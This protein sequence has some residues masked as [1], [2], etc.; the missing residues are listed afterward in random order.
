[1]WIKLLLGGVKHVPSSDRKTSL[2]ITNITPKTLLN[3]FPVTLDDSNLIVRF[4]DDDEDFG[5]LFG[6]HDREGFV[7]KITGELFEDAEKLP[8]EQ[9]NPEYFPSLEVAEESRKD[10]YGTLFDHLHV[11]W[12]EFESDEAFTLLAFNGIGMYYLAGIPNDSKFK[13]KLPSAAVQID[14]DFMHQFACREPY[15]RYGCIAYFDI[16]KAPVAIYW[17]AGDK[18]V[19]PGDADWEHA[20]FVFRC[21]L[22][23]VI[24]CK[25]HLINLHWQVSNTLMFASRQSL[26]EHHALRRLI[27]PHT[28]RVAKINWVSRATL[29]PING[30]AHRTFAL[31]AGAFHEFMAVGIR[32]LKFQTF[33]DEIQSK[34]LP[35]EIASDLPYKVDGEALWSVI[36]SYVAAYMNIFYPSDEDVLKDSSIRQFYAHYQS[37]A[38]W[39]DYKVS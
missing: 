31:E 15:E 17:S 34:N 5:D 26:S 29:F 13:D 19:Y 11:K 3:V 33:P 1:M 39:I 7:G 18:L 32:C 8:F 30:L 2:D 38:G 25:D 10:V 21:T 37:P 27:K 20:K 6:F 23:V 16:N 9:E 35:P 24:T 4:T 28:F 36:R 22:C 14:M 12:D